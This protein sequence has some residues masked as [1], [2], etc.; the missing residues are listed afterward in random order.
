[1]ESVTRWVVDRDGATLARRKGRAWAPAWRIDAPL[2]GL[3]EPLRV[4]P[5]PA[6]GLWRVEWSARLDARWELAPEAPWFGLTGDVAGPTTTLGQG[7]RSIYG[8][9]NFGAGFPAGA[10][11]NDGLL[12]ALLLDIGPMDWFG[13]S[14][15]RRFLD[16]RVVCEARDGRGRLGLRFPGAGPGAIEAGTVAFA[17]WVHAAEVPTRPGGLEILARTVAAFAPCHPDA[18]PGPKDAPSWEDLARRTVAGLRVPGKSLFERPRN[19]TDRPHA[20]S[21]PVAAV[22][23]HPDRVGNTGGDFS[24]VNNHL[25]P[26][27][28]HARLHPDDAEG[29]AL[30]LRKLHQLP[31][32]YD[33]AADLVGWNPDGRMS[34]AMSWQTLSFHIECLRASDAA[35]DDAFDP[36]ASGRVLMATRGLRDWMRRCGDH[37]PQWWDVPQRAPAV[38]NDV[39]ELGVVREPWQVGAYAEILLRA[40]GIAREPALETEAARALRAVASGRI[41]QNPGDDP[42]DFPITELFG[43]AYGAVAARR[44]FARTRDPAWQTLS[45]QMLAT[46]LRLTPWGEDASTPT[47]RELRSLGLFYPHGGAYNLTP[48]ETNEATL[49]LAW[50]LPRLPESPVRSLL[51]RLVNCHRLHGLDF[52]PAAWSEPVR[53]HHGETVA[54]PWDAF[55]IEPFHTLEGPGGHR[56]L[57]ALYKPTALWNAWCFEALAGCDDPAW[58]ALNLATLEGY[59]AALEGVERRVLVHNGTGRRG[60]ICLQ[61]R[62]LPPGTYRVDGDPLPRTVRE[63]GETLRLTVTLPAGGHRGVTVRAADDGARARLG[64]RLAERDAL[65]ARYRALQEDRNAPEAAVRRYRDDLERFRRG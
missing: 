28:L 11:W 20:L 54:P 16:G 41:A 63:P 42:V 44:L 65:S 37:L 7:P 59:A 21:P 22:V 4:T 43:N 23:T 48:W 14:S 2:A 30:A 51:V 47:A 5:G 64:R 33:D 25:S 32:F 34:L 8:G 35:P 36:A 13:R 40:A 53:R 50:L 62:R 29:R 39:P 24:T 10:L 61:V 3:A 27:L 45:D 18:T 31:C 46:L 38:Q 9:S 19:W 6:P 56:G 1:M 12:V 49:C 52:F 57:P 17:A 15:R 60:T 58:M 55:P 26:S